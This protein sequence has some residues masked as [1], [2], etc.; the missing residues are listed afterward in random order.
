MTRNLP[1]KNMKKTQSDSALAKVQNLYILQVELWN[2]LDGDDLKEDDFK[3]AQKNL[4]QF[5]SLMKEV[6][7]RYMGGED[8][9]ETLE[10]IQKEVAM[11]LKSASK[12]KRTK[13]KATVKKAVKKVVKKKSASKKKKR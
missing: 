11:K 5:K 2:F 3:R 8:V 12:I 4:R 9:L 7:W 10:R 1:Y 13:K 6:D